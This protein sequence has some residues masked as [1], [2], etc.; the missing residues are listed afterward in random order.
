[1]LLPCSVASY[2]R[3]SMWHTKSVIRTMVYQLFFTTC[4]HACIYLAI[5]VA[6]R[7]LC[8]PFSSASWSRKQRKLQVVYFQNYLPDWVCMYWDSVHWVDATDCWQIG[9]EFRDKPVWCYNQQI[10]LNTRGK[11]SKATSHFF[12]VLITRTRGEDWHNLHPIPL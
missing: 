1:M 2:S 3:S 11:N 6:K 10:R 9:L 7:D 4:L 5:E 8:P 12:N